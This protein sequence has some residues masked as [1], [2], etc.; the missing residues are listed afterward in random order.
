MPRSAVPNAQFANVY[1]R[2]D[3]LLYEAKS[4]GRNRTVSERLQAFGRRREDRRLGRRP[5][6]AA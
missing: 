4:Q 3:M 6:Q 1:S 5:T 2:V